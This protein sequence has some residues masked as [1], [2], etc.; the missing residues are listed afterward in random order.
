MS[1][2]SSVLC[3]LV[4]AIVSVSSDQ[5]VDVS[6]LKVCTSNDDCVS[7]D[8][9]DQLQQMATELEQNLTYASTDHITPSYDSFFTFNTGTVQTVVMNQCNAFGS[10]YLDDITDT[11]NDH[12]TTTATYID[13]VYGS[14]S[15]ILDKEINPKN[16][17]Y[18]IQKP[19]GSLVR[20]YC[21][22]TTD[23]CAGSGGW[24]RVGF[25]NT[26]STDADLKKCPSPLVVKTYDS[27]SYSLCQRASGGAGCDSIFYSSLGFSYTQVCGRAKGYTF[28]SP[29]TFTP[30][31]IDE[32]YIDGL[33]VT[34]GSG[35]RTHIWSFVGGVN[36]DG[37]EHWDCSCNS[38]NPDNP[39]P[40][41]GN[42]YY[43]ETGI[44]QGESWSPGRLHPNDPLWDGEQCESLEGGCCKASALPYFV[45]DLGK[46]ITDDLEIRVCDD[47]LEDNERIP[48]ELLEFYVK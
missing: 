38:F 2:T 43:C 31:S 22:M 3:V 12:L 14:C 13:K 36:T 47:E 5:L 23:K 10:Q 6:D 1:L 24:M 32:N 26:N 37:V 17:Y 29:D 46:T 27:L 33:S 19:D 25:F 18:T 21:H 8:K 9:I 40:F 30:G 45:K 4:L 42:D 28:G 39:P 41:V 11:L 16:G 7:I 34:Y 15:D 20:V 48:L 35:P 44:P